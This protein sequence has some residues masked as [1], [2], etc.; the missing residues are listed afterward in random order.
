MTGEPIPLSGDPIRSYYVMSK[1]SPRQY[2][3]STPER[4][5]NCMSIDVRQKL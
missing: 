5:F 3:E 1:R 4:Y 2:T